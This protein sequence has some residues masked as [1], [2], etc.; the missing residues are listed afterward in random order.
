VSD[1]PIT[2]IVA[3]FGGVLSSPL[4]DAFDTVQRHYELPSDA[5]GAALAA[6]AAER[7]A[8][9]LHDLE[10]GAI[11]EAAFF[12]RL[13]DALTTHLGRPVA[14]AD[15]TA[16][17]WAALTPNDELIEHLRGLRRGGYRM[18]L[19]TN[20]VREWGP[21]WRAMVPVDEL[22]D[23]VVDSAWVGLRKPDPAI[24]ALTSERLGVRP[25]EIVLL[26]DLAPNC[27]AARD[28]GWAAVRFD[29]TSQTIAE[30]DALLAARGAPR[31]V[32]ARADG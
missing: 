32:E 28:A 9:P 14:I 16:R 30:L 8:H 29:T 27:H 2:T 5:L 4:A 31:G 25:Q 13:G 21:Y 10:T 22:F 1:G 26:D 3:D 7:G 12:D 20:N 23:A 18:G 17:Y 19:L 24:Y 15:F 11:G 6:V